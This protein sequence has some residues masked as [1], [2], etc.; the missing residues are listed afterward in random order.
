MNGVSVVDKSKD[1]QMELMME[2]LRSKAG[3]FKTFQETSKNV[4]MTMLDKRYALDSVDKAQHQKCLDTL[5]HCIKVTSFQS[6]VERLES[7]TRQLGLKFTVGPSGAELFISSDMFY[8]E[9]IL[10]P[11]ERGGGVRDV[12]IHHEGKNEQQSCAELVH[13]LSRQDFADFTL[14]LEGLASIYQLNAE[15]KVKS[16][17]FSALQALETDLNTLGQLQTYMKEQPFNLLHKSPVGI[18]EKRRGGHAMKLT[19]LVSPYELIDTARGRADPLT[20]ER[21]ISRKLGYSATVCI[22]GST[23]HKLPITPIISVNRN[24]NTNNNTPSYAPL[25][26]QNSAVIPAYFT[27]RLSKQMCV[28]TVLAKRI[29]ALTQLE[30][31]DLSTTHP[32]LSLITQLASDGQLDCANNRGMFVTLP[33]QQ[34]CYFLTEGRNLQGVVINSI[35]FTHPAHVP[36]ILSLLRQQALFNTVLSSCIRPNSKQDLENMIMFEVNA[37]SWQNLS[38]SLEH[39]IEESMATADIDLTDISNVTCKIYGPNNTN[40]EPCEILSEIATKVL[41][42]CLSIP[43]TMRAVI[44]AWE[45]MHESKKYINGNENF[46]LPLG[47]DDPGGHNGSNDSPL[48]DYS[49]LDA[50]MKSDHNMSSGN[51]NMSSNNSHQSTFMS[52]TLVG[53]PTFSPNQ[54]LSAIESNLSSSIPSTSE[55][56]YKKHKRKS[57]EDNW[58]SSK[59]KQ[60]DDSD[61]FAETS[62]SDSISTPLSHD[63]TSDLVVSTPTSTLGFQS[64]FDLSG[65]DATELITG[66]KNCL[67]FDCSTDNNDLEDILSSNSRSEMKPRSNKSKTETSDDLDKQVTPSVSITPI[68]T[69]T[70]SSTKL[71]FMLNE[72]ERRPGIEII[73]ITS[74]SSTTLPSSI[75]ITPITSTTTKSSES[76][77]SDRKVSKSSKSDE[78]SKLEKKRKRKREE[79]GMNPPDKITI[80]QDPL[81]KPVSVSIKP[82]DI[83]S[84]PSSPSTK[85]SSSSSTSSSPTHNNRTLSKQGSPSAKHSTSKLSNNMH[86]H[87]GKNLSKS[88][89][90]GGVVSPK[91]HSASPKHSSSG[92]GKPS[93]STLKSATNVPVSKSSNES[94][95]SSRVKSSKD[96]IRDKDKKSSSLNSMSNSPNNSV[97]YSG[98]NKLK[99]SSVKLKQLNLPLNQDSQI[100]VDTL[101]SSP[102]G[103]DINK[104]A[105]Q[106]QARNRKGMGLSAIVDNLQKKAAQHCPEGESPPSGGGSNTTSSKNSTS[107]NRTNLQSSKLD[108]NKSISKSSSEN[109]NSE[110]MV[111]PSSDG[112]KI[113]I[114]KTRS[115]ETKSISQNSMS[116]S[117]VNCNNLKIATGSSS[118]KTHTGLKPGVNSGPASKKPQVQGSQKQ[119]TNISS[120]NSPNVLKNMSSSS[121]SSS[122]KSSSLSKSSSSS[123]ISSKSSSK[124]SNSMDRNKL[125]TSFGGKIDK[126]LGLSRSSDLRRS[127]PTILSSRDRDETDG[128]ERKLLKN[129]QSYPSPLFEGLIKQ[130]LDTKFQIPKLSKTAAA[131]DNDKKPKLINNQ[132][133]DLLNN[134]SD[135]SPRNETQNLSIFTNNIDDK[136]KSDNNMR[137]PSSY[138]D[139]QLSNITKSSPIHI[140]DESSTSHK[141]DIHVNNIDGGGIDDSTPS[142]KMKNFQNKEINL[143]MNSHDSVHGGSGSSSKSSSSSSHHTELAMK[144][145]TTTS[146]QV[147]EMLLDF[148]PPSTNEHLSKLKND[149][150]SLQNMLPSVVHRSSSLPSSPSVSVHIMK[151]P[152]P[153]PLIIPSPHSGSPCIT[154]DDLMDE[155]LVGIGK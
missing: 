26:P 5:Q 63:A 139:T 23:A 83:L 9:V 61:I 109:K 80:K 74:T 36:Q 7:L 130:Q 15:K 22:E 50:K 32:L 72:I 3:Q 35:P 28:C 93:M 10:E 18:L 8:L 71:N 68:T 49:N 144:V 114:N 104:I 47:S 141:K 140:N 149:A 122:S 94:S 66:D 103:L 42:R 78:K 131:N 116:N 43:V 60:N 12:K 91:H 120:S 99:S 88:S 77:R 73:P 14:Q 106:N 134:R 17:A 59:R 82:T 150:S 27:L 135:A 97:S 75:T 86:H 132:I 25:T 65:L 113:T 105:L 79:D 143:S 148:T 54:A 102:T 125:R 145:V 16:K 124:L 38:I 55:K 24:I 34:H 100:N 21:V 67:D 119:P 2:K 90:P 29:Q 81:T 53:F 137:I 154:D 117:V 51:S 6:M 37:L 1:W 152:A 40:G 19:Y 44:K 121:S 129:D 64:D 142:C 115:K 33:D 85:H 41:Q 4:R 89:S 58:K 11:N 46:S 136:S 133:N 155:A 92:T 126:S 62:S 153:S 112:M 98:S 110:Y 31:G 30:C 95:S 111:K 108:I 146:Q 70:S 69:T 151:S 52:D 76:N 84:L 39:P 45:E 48:P 13:C 87:S 20:V 128:N 118:P 123:M 96:V 56:H 147:A 57:K 138:A 101:S 107:S 127:S